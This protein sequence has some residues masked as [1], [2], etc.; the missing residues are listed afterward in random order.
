MKKLSRLAVLATLLAIGVTG[1][2]AWPAASLATVWADHAYSVGRCYSSSATWRGAEANIEVREGEISDADASAGGFVLNTL[3]VLSTPNTGWVECG[4][5]RGYRG[6]NIRTPYWYCKTLAG[7]GYWHKVVNVSLVNGDTPRF[8]I[9]KTAADEA[10]QCTIGGVAAQ[11]SSGDSV[12]NSCLGTHINR[13]EVGLECC[14]SSGHLGSVGD[15]IDISD[16]KKKAGDGTWGFSTAGL[17]YI[18]GGD[19]QDITHG[20]WVT[21]SQSSHNYRND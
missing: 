5:M 11:D 15:W 9:E 2:A 21:T 19:P 8:R 14:A 18:L 17:S 1:L 7:N 4:Y 10:W 16:Q 20:S 13:Y 6:D 12:A 3:W